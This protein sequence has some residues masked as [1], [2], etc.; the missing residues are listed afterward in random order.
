MTENTL[1]HLP[2]RDAITGEPV[3]VW[4]HYPSHPTLGGGRHVLLDTGCP[5]GAD[6]WLTPTAALALADA[7]RQA[8][9]AV[10]AARDDDEA[11]R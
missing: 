3:K 4:P 11:Q 1:T 7:L 9:A 5:G 6:L 10:I 8:A 2:I